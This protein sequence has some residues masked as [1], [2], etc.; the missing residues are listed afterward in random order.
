MIVIAA[1]EERLCL[2][3][4]EG[5]VVLFVRLRRKSGVWFVQVSVVEVE[6]DR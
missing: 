2:C 4:F 3:V 5:V 6:S 1:K